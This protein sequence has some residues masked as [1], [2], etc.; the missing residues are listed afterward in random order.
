[1]GRRNQPT[2]GIRTPRENIYNKSPVTRT[3]NSRSDTN[4]P[5]DTKTPTHETTA[6]ERFVR[7]QQP[8]NPPL[9]S[10]QQGGKLGRDSA[11]MHVAK[12]RAAHV[13]NFRKPNLQPL[14]KLP[15]SDDHD[16][17]KL[18]TKK[19]EADTC[20]GSKGEPHLCSP[21]LD[22]S[23]RLCSPEL[24]SQRLC[25]PDLVSQLVPEERFTS[26]YTLTILPR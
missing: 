8:A 25:S 20:A 17:A 9:K 11:K 13:C 18:R 15:S 1:M 2:V 3:P 12:P 23:Q 7:S 24:V 22:M 6:R 16:D 4:S 21:E 10:V 5:K 19:V 26:S 14:G